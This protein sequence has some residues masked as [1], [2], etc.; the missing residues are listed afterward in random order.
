MV[1]VEVKKGE[2]AQMRQER[3]R[4]EKNARNWAKSAYSECVAA[5]RD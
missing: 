5:W 1:V 2:H 4:K 3:E